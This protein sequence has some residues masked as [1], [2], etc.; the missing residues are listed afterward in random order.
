MISD[1]LVGSNKV[2]DLQHFMQ[3]QI[4]VDLFQSSNPVT[5]NI[6]GM[7]LSQDF[8]CLPLQM[9]TLP[10]CVSILWD[11]NSNASE[12]LTLTSHSQRQSS[13]MFSLQTRS[14]NLNAAMKRRPQHL[15]MCSVST[16]LLVF[17]F[18][19]G[20]LIYLTRETNSHLD[21]KYIFVCKK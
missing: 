15:R 14:Q 20:A 5:L 9:L 10:T 3:V 17:S 12:L 16:F 7:H 19:F 1:S 13:Q 4:T 21:I 2:G 18:L 11:D 6:N 8:S